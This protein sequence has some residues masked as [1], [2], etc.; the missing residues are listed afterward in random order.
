MHKIPLF[1]C[2]YFLGC[3]S[4]KCLE[5]NS[6]I[7]VRFIG[8]FKA[9]EKQ[10]SKASKDDLRYYYSEMKLKEKIFSKICKYLN[11]TKKLL[12]LE[13]ESPINSSRIGLVYLYEEDKYINFVVDL[14]LDI[15]AGGGYKNYKELKKVVDIVKQDFNK[16]TN[17]LKDYFEKQSMSDVP[18]LRLA[19]IDLTM[20]NEINRLNAFRFSSDIILS[21]RFDN[22]FGK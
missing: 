14:D 8:I 21:D 5:S 20:S 19:F 1:I 3:S 11:G 2:F 12:Y 16:Q 22:E 6:D 10:L 18:Y 9:N 13:K 15:T 4:N 17:R 7:Y